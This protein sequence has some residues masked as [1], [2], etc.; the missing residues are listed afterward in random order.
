MRDEN[1]TK[2]QLINE[3]VACRRQISELEKLE[4]DQLEQRYPN[5]I[6]N[7]ADIIYTIST[8]GTITS[9]NPAFERITGLSA[10]EWVGKNFARI[11][12]PDDL[13]L[14]WEKFECALRGEVP[15]KFELRSL[16][17]SGEYLFGEFT[18]TALIRDGRV[19]GVLGIVRD[20]TERKQME[21][22]LRA[23]SFF[24]D[25][26]GLY[27]RRGFF[28]FADEFLKLAKRQRQGLFMLYA[29]LDNLKLTNDTL[30]HQAGDQALLDSAE[31]IKKTYRESDIVAR[32]GGDEFAVI[33]IGTTGD[34]IEKLTSR[35]QEN[36]ENHNSTRKRNYALSMSFGVSYYDPTAPCSIDELVAQADEMMYEQKRLKKKS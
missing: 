26:T 25:L 5:L 31:I 13:S 16:S 17:K 36:I 30:G 24:D 10:D 33:P 27:N 4:R 15:P 2:A 28:T 34:N 3:L 12:H 20:I 19:D 14:A 32:I 29:D 6:E 35:L 18:A 22:Q 11:I 23:L 1:K 21:E 8:D 9:L 7:I